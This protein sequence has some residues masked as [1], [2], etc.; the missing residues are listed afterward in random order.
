MQTEATHQMRDRA[1][2]TSSLL[3][4]SRS[5]QTPTS[6]P[7]L[8]ALPNIDVLPP[9]RLNWTSGTQTP[10]QPKSP[11]FGYKRMYVGKVQDYDDLHQ[12][13]YNSVSLPVSPQCVSLNVSKS[14]IEKSSYRRMEDD[15]PREDSTF[16]PKS[17]SSPYTLD[18][19]SLRTKLQARA[20]CL[21]SL[22]EQLRSREREVLAKEQK[23]RRKELML[24]GVVLR[25]ETDL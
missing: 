21:D 15:L 24:A 19:S 4:L 10:E 20:T 5:S 13:L 6:Y 8:E 12:L 17:P 25:R 14:R 11:E 3:S 1:S 7:S 16:T 9:L 23:V 22:T 2:Q 18:L